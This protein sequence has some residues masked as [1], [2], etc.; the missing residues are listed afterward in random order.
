MSTS[1]KL[2]W[3]C[4]NVGM[5]PKCKMSTEKHSSK[6]AGLLIDPCV[7]QRDI[8][9]ASA[10]DRLCEHHSDQSMVCCSSNRGATFDSC[11]GF[12][13][14]PLQTSC[15]FVVFSRGSICN[16]I[17][18]SLEWEPV[19]WLFR[20]KGFCEM[21]FRKGKEPLAVSTFWETNESRFGQACWRLTSLWWLLVASS[22]PLFSSLMHDWADLMLVLIDWGPE[23]G[24]SHQG[25]P[26]VVA[27]IRLVFLRWCHQRH[28][29]KLNAPL[30]TNRRSF[31]L[32]RVCCS[33]FCA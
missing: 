31:W 11:H 10:E 24:W 4:Q 7:V 14:R 27:D 2:C 9:C 6:L 30:E 23:S 15:A 3:K 28:H 8:L 5:N 18:Q 12:N 33:C 1:A 32:E 21:F 20:S 25:L 16:K 19:N 22:S 13:N 29:S 26:S 17:K